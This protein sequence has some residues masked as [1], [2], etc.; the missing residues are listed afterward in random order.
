MPG[1]HEPSFCLVC[2]DLNPGTARVAARRQK[3]D[4]QG[5]PDGLPK[6]HPLQELCWRLSCHCGGCGSVC[7]CISFFWAVAAPEHVVWMCVPPYLDGNCSNSH[8]DAFRA[9]ISA[10]SLIQII[11][12]SAS[13]CPFRSDLA[14]DGWGQTWSNWNP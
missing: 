7:G 5:H 11:F 8:P 9:Q 1:T 14:G 3:P 4:S 6:L 12:L 2:S 10:F 13:S